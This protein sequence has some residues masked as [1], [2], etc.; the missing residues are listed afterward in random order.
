MKAL[1]LLNLFAMSALAEGQG[2]LQLPQVLEGTQIVERLR[3]RIDKSLMFTR[4]DGAKVSLSEYFG[5]SNKK[6]IPTIV[7]LGY[8][9][10]PMLCTLVLNASCD[11]FEKLSL[12][13]GEDYRVLSF[14]INPKETPD[15]AANNDG[16]WGG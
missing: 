5:P 9:E 15:L 4:H 12:R 13:M 10:C 16:D 11:A 7:T 14:S 6:G 1:W 3:A 8:F 2:S